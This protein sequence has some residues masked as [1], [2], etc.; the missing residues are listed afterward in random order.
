MSPVSL[1]LVGAGGHA[2]SC[3]DVVEQH[4]GFRIA[5]L[6]GMPEEAGTR[7]LGYEVLGSDEHLPGLVATVGS[8]LI[9]VGHMKSALPRIRMSASTSRSG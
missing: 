6:I 2:A 1:L 5:G 4:G 8:A 7:V 9:A 3:I